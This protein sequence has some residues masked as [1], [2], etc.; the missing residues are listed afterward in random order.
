MLHQSKGMHSPF[1]PLSAH[2]SLLHQ[3]G[4]WVRASDRRST[5]DPVIAVLAGA[6]LNDAAVETASQRPSQNLRQLL[7]TMTQYDLLEAPLDR[8][9]WRRACAAAFRRLARRIAGWV[10]ARRLRD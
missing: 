5:L 3:W 4:H 8:A 7:S 10:T 2:A 6:T 9:A 1:V